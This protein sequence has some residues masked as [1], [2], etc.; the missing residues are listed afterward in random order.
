MPNLVRFL[1]LHAAI[2]FGLA[3]LLVMGLLLADPGGASVV[4]RAS[5]D[6]VPMLLLWLF[7]GMTFAAV[8]FGA[9]VMLMEQR[10]PAPVRNRVAV[11][12]R[13]S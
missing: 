8:Q 5:G 4:L 2:G 6:P 13:P 9:A 11:R 3:A 12:H 10:E 1:L 7:T